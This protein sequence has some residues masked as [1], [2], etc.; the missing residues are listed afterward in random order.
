MMPFFSIIIPVY[1]VALYLRECLDSVLSQTFTDWEAIC[2]DDG[3][4][5]G[6]GAILDEYAAKDKRLRVFH[7]PNAGVSAARNKALDNISGEWVWC[8]DGDDMLHP[9]AL[10]I[11]AQSISKF[12]EVDG[13]RIEFQVGEVPSAEWFN[14]TQ[15]EVAEYSDEYGG[16]MAARFMAGIWMVIMKS[17]C[18]KH[19]RFEPITHNEDGIFVMQ[20]YW[21]S[22]GWI[23]LPAKLYFW[24][25]R[26]DSATHKKPSLEYVAQTFDSGHM[27]L[28]AVLAN[29]RRWSGADL[30]LLFQ[31]LHCRD[32]YSYFGIYF[33]LNAKDRKRLLTQWLALQYRY[34]SLYPIPR[35]RKLRIKI[36]GL[37]NS[38]LM[39]KYIALG[40]WTLTGLC[41]ALGRRVW[42]CLSCC[43]ARGN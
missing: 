4:T 24:R 10:A 42:R 19:I 20:F 17:S 26:L 29:R 32:Y 38:G 21:R 12:I 5:D 23:Y 37:L 35:G 8:V 40:N 36:A 1:N 28:D 43:C 18:L 31:A 2:V 13:I 7:Q 6:S 34:Y 27:Q 16:D 15:C 11:V 39:V 41:R 3:S 30:K 22:K 9:E 25:Q 14:R 33:Q